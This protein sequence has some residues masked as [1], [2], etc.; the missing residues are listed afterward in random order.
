MKKMLIGAT[1]ALAAMA[2]SASGVS[3]QADDYTEDTESSVVAD[4]ECVDLDVGDTPQLTYSFAASAIITGDVFLRFFDGATQ[5]GS[6]VDITASPSAGTIDFPLNGASYTADGWEDSDGILVQGSG[7]PTLTVIALA[8]VGSEWIQSP[9]A[10]VGYDCAAAGPPEGGSID[11]SVATVDCTADVPYIR[12]TID[13]DGIEWPGEAE[14]TLFGT[15]NGQRVQVGQF[16]VTSQTGRFLYPGASENPLDWPGWSFV[17]GEWVEEDPNDPGSDAFLRDG[18]IVS[19][20]VNPTVERTVPYPLGTPD[21]ADPPTSESQSPPGTPQRPTAR[22]LPSTGL[23]GLEIF[24]RTASVVSLAGIGLLIA[25]RR[26]RD[27]TAA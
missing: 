19:I 13:L 5:W 17:N 14:I 22:P 24:V 3:A 21:C 10:T 8:E 4:G 6:D 18:V 2:F 25:A 26:R 20:E 1:T 16:D 9:V 23:S 12:Y 15:R 7:F 27:A 11:G